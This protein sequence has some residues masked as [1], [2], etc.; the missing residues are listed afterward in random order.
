M[1]YQRLQLVA[2]AGHCRLA[3]TTSVAFHHQSGIAQRRCINDHQSIITVLSIRSCLCSPRPLKVE[4]ERKDAPDG[5]PAK[6]TPGRAT[7]PRLNPQQA[8]ARSVK[9][10]SA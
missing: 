3:T 7:P 6:G 1:A 9:G 8:N 5:Q 2:R 4:K 10:M